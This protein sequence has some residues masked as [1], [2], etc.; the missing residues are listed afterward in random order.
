V[1]FKDNLA[2]LVNLEDTLDNLECTVHHL[3][4]FKDN[5]EDTLEDFLEGQ[6]MVTQHFNEVPSNMGRETTTE[7]RTFSYQLASINPLQL[8]NSFEMRLNNLEILT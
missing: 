4:A 2:S 6:D 1:A 7:D 3:A 8:R 5:L